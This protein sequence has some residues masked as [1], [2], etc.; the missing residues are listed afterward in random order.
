MWVQLKLSDVGLRLITIANQM[1]NE[2]DKEHFNGLGI[3]LWRFSLVD[4]VR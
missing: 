1:T 3:P 4:E 2:Y